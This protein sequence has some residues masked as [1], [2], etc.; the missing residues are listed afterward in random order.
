V[1]TAIATRR[2]IRPIV[3]T[4]AW[5]TIALVLMVVTADRHASSPCGPRRRLRL[6]GGAAM[7][8]HGKLR[9][10]P[11]APGSICV[12]WVLCLLGAARSRDQI[13]PLRTPRRHST[14]D[15]STA[16][17]RPTGGREIGAERD[18]VQSRRQEHR[19]G[20]GR[21]CQRHARHPESA[22]HR[23]CAGGAF[24][25]SLSGPGRDGGQGRHDGD[26]TRWLRTW[27]R[28][29]RQATMRSCFTRL[30]K[31]RHWESTSRRHQRRVQPVRPR[32][33][34]LL[35]LRRHAG[36]R[37]HRRQR[38]SRCSRISRSIHT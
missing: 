25:H 16:R 13:R 10:L 6:I 33:L 38:R 31:W 37:D 21:L 8:P 3:L 9:R 4:F 5:S 15:R 24:L 36:A 7:T 1:V 26:S 12:C 35:R 28:P 17:R 30:A 34:P 27:I 32:R 11:T 22:P 29:G 19:R 18:G 14:P 2:S 23:A 20:Q